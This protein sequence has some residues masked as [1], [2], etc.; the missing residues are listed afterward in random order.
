MYQV[1][2]TSKELPAFNNH[3]K[4]IYS[5]LVTNQVFP[6]GNIVNG[7]H[8]LRC[9]TDNFAPIE[10]YLNLIGKQVVVCGA[11]YQDGTWHADYPCNQVE[12]DKHMQQT[13][14]IDINGNSVT[15]QP[16]D[17]ISAGWTDFNYVMPAPEEI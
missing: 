14:H 2:F 8:L 6:I 4:K 15:L 12:F 3:D 13:N 5:Q 9:M 11:R 16:T 7:R 17:N 10:Y 1:W